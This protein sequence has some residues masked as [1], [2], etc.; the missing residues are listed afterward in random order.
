LFNFERKGIN[1]MKKTKLL[2]YSLIG[3]LTYGGVLSTASAGIVE[4]QQFA[5]E[6]SMEERRSEI[7]ALM[8]REDVTRELYAMGVD[9]E[10]AQKRIASLSDAE[11]QRLHAQLDELP[12]GSGV[13][14]AILIV[15]LI[16]ILLD[17]AGATD[18]FPKV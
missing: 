2:T 14:G 4:T 12:A 8:A 6:I 15:V 18:I 1:T 13:L 17:I 10:E 9:A 11:L 7:Q 3:V 5:T 16:L